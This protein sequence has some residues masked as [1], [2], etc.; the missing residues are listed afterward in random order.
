MLVLLK[1]YLW[2]LL[3][4]YKNHTIY[5]YDVI[6][7]ILIFWLRIAII[8]LLLKTIYLAGDTQTIGWFTVVQLSIAMMFSQ[9]ISVSKPDIT[10]LIDFD[11]KSW[12]ISSYMLNPISYVWFKF[13]ENFA[14]FL[15]NVVVFMVLGILI[16]L[17]IFGELTTSMF[18]VFGWIVM[19]LLSMLISFFG[20][21]LMGLFAF[22]VEDSQPFRW[23]YSKIDMLLGWD[24]LPLTFLPWIWQ[25]I[26]FSL[27]FAYW[28]YTAG[29]VFS[30][31]SV[32]TFLFFF[33]VQLIWIIVFVILCL[34]IYSV[35]KKKMNINWG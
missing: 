33:F 21:M 30:N 15:F 34:R 6:W 9:V 35:W 4:S 8:S 22:F 25:T 27:P 1:K 18:W 19:I 14:G 3:I 28:G 24:I 31:F 2:I 11:I 32:N 13:F 5:V 10:K 29:L 17:L 20:Y 12:K 23:I 26:A 7:N 16:I